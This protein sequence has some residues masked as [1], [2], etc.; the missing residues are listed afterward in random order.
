MTAKFRN[1]T[2][3]QDH[4]NEETEI[5]SDFRDLRCH[6]DCIND[7]NELSEVKSNVIEA[8]KSVDSMRTA[9]LATLKRL[10]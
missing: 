5:D 9:L 7:T 6:L 4:I 10:G 3:A 1:A 8:L 2:E